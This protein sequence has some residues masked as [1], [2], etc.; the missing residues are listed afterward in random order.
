M[1]AKNSIS[2]GELLKL[3]LLYNRFIPLKITKGIIEKSITL[4]A[5]LL[6]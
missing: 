4:F 6:L 1:N 5:T 3:L 2:R